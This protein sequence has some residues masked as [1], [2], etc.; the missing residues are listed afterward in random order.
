MRGTD[1]WS[2]VLA[3]DTSEDVNVAEPSEGEFVFYT[4]GEEE[5]V[6]TDRIVD[7]RAWR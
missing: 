7:V 3:I 6:R 1:D 4:E 2:E 5:Y